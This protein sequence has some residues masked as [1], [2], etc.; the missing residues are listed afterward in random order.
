MRSNV[1]LTLLLF[2]C[3]AN[4][5]TVTSTMCTATGFPPVSDPNSCEINNNGSTSLNVRASITPGV[6]TLGSAMEGVQSEF[7]DV[8][9][10]ANPTVPLP[11]K[12][13]TQASAFAGGSGE[14]QLT[15]G[16][17]VR[18]GFIQFF[19]NVVLSHGSGEPLRT[20]Q[21]DINVGPLHT[22]CTAV[23][24]SPPGAN[25][26]G[27]FAP[28]NG[29]ANQRLPFT[30]GQVFLFSDDI[31]LFGIGSSRDFLFDGPPTAVGSLSFSFSL[32]EADGT[33]VQ[34][35]AVPEPGPRAL[36]LLA[37]FIAAGALVK[38]RRKHRLP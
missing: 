3:V 23:G 11:G 32:L 38:V 29:M 2:A 24:P 5:S 28:F 9:V 33:P 25:C 17:P 10:V 19:E 8:V 30:L 36:L 14:L 12:P 22:T 1:S 13:D 21:A 20:G 37:A 15:T 6:L 35:Y 31:T 18:S 34:M 16:G 27:D 26:T 4:A 7:A